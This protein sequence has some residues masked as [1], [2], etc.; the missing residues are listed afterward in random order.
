L[1]GEKWT[2]CPDGQFGTFGEGLYMHLPLQKGKGDFVQIWGK[3][4]AAIIQLSCYVSDV[5]QL[6]VKCQATV[7]C[8]ATVCQMSAVNQLS[9]MCQATVSC[10]SAVCQ[11]SNNC[12]VSV[13][14]Q[15][16]VSVN[17][18]SISCQITVLSLVKQLSV[19]C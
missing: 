18:L 9:V 7:S 12:Q 15:A 4:Q 1:R 5:K 19:T 11:L 17:Q 13:R 16:T 3:C 6:S 2:C 8:Q 14:C 10:Q